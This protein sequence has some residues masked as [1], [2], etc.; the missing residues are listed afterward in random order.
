MEQP[1]SSFQFWRGI[2]LLLVPYP[3]SETY[4]VTNF[5]LFRKHNKGVEKQANDFVFESL[6]KSSNIKNKF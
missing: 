1:K 6:M 4:N 2:A 3:L 5:L